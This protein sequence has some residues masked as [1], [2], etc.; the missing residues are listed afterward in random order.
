[1]DK[2]NNHA[3]KITDFPSLKINL[4]NLGNYFSQKEINTTFI[5]EFISKT[6][7][8]GKVDKKELFSWVIEIKKAYPLGFN[9]LNFSF[10][11]YLNVCEQITGNKKELSHF[12]LRLLQF[13]L[14]V[15]KHQAFLT[16]TH[17][18]WNKSVSTKYIFEIS[19]RLYSLGVPFFDFF[20]SNQ[21]IRNPLDYQR[22]KHF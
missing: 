11:V 14:K 19:K 22:K 15:Y 20:F 7:H 8:A 6:L 2:F 18:D 21:F 3:A 5:L 12:E 13:V 4:E 9:G 17:Y 10:L 1:M 16:P